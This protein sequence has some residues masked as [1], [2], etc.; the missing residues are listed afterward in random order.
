MF[1]LGS[2]A[3]QTVKATNICAVCDKRFYRSDS[4]E[5]HLEV[6]FC[7]YDCPIC[8]KPHTNQ[9]SLDSHITNQHSGTSRKR[10]LEPDQIPEAGENTQAT[11]GK[12]S[13]YI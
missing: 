11:A 12:H 6:H 4:Y 10:Q 8:R 9:P 2:G 1:I 5:A 7:E 13:A 3:A